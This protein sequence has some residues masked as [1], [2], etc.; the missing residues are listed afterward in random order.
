MDYLFRD[1][2][3]F[4]K[5][6]AVVAMANQYLI[7]HSIQQKDRKLVSLHLMTTSAFLIA[8]FLSVLCFAAVRGASDPKVVKVSNTSRVELV[9]D[10][11]SLTL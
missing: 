1:G 6:N 9:G 8:A 3:H 5:S 2:K 4:H 7:I 11:D 10:K